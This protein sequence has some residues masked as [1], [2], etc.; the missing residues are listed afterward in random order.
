MFVVMTSLLVFT[1]GT[2][3]SWFSFQHLDWS[4]LERIGVT[5][6]KYDHLR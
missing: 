3:A 2:N 5:G 4:D 6:I 1:V